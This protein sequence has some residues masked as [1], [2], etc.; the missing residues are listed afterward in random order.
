MTGFQINRRRFLA[1]SG[2]FT[3]VS[4]FTGRAQETKDDAPELDWEKVQNTDE[5]NAKC[6]RFH[7]GS[8]PDIRLHVALKPRK[9]DAEGESWGVPNVSRFELVWD[10]QKVEISGR[11]WQDI[12]RM[13]LQLYPE[14]ELGKIPMDK[15]WKIE[16]AIRKLHRPRLYLS[17]GKGTVM[18]EWPRGEECDSSSTFR[19]IISKTG[20]VLRHHEMGWHEC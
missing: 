17:A 18:I 14:A 1:V 20:T 15:R 4:T 2:M 16:S 12:E 19:W 9:P 3:T 11:F 5:Y 13:P 6:E 8:Y 7:D 10:K